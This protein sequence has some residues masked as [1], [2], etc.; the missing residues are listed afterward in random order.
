VHQVWERWHEGCSAVR[1]QEVGIMQ[2]PSGALEYTACSSALG[3]RAGHQ[4]PTPS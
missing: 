3:L 2:P 4:V 1:I